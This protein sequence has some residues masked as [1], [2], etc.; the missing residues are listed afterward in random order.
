MAAEENYLSK[1]FGAAFDLS[2]PIF[3][4][5]HGP[6]LHFCEL[7][8]RDPI[9]KLCGGREEQVLS[10]LGDLHLRPWI[11]QFGSLEFGVFRIHHEAF[12]EWKKS[13]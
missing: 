7:H 1:R 13:S 5:S 12:E 11:G 8:R 4:H 3:G 2:K 10:R 6:A 9:P